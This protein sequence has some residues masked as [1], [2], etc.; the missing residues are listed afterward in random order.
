LPVDFP[1]VSPAAQTFPFPLKPPAQL[2]LTGTQRGGL[3]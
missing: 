2:P 1:S 3:I